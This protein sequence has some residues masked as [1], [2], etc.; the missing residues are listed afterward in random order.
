MAFPTKAEQER[1]AQHAVYDADKER[2]LQEIYRAF[3]IIPRNAANDGMIDE[4]CT[5]FL[6]V[7]KGEVAPTLSTFRSA[8]AAD[9]TLLGGGG[10]GVSIEPVAQ[11]KQKKILD[12]EK[13]LA[14]IMSPQDLRSELNKLS[15]W[16]LE[17]VQARKQQ[18]IERQ[19]LSKLSSADIKQEL[20]ANRPKPN[21]YHP[22]EELPEMTAS[23]L[24]AVLRSYKSNS[25]L[26]RY[27]AE[28][29]ND[30]LF[31]RI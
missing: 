25:Y 14:G 10:D 9:P 26:R 24:K 19:R 22:Y 23:D 3:P 17:Q 28:Q 11:Q 21:R 16:S 6:G 5:T 27:G 13:L 8:V 12:I 1:K 31:G 30:K 15:L 4:I 18:I 29:L 2:G 20:A 7:P